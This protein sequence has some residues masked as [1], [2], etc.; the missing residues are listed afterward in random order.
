[1]ESKKCK[2]CHGRGFKGRTG[3][4][5]LMTVDDSIRDCINTGADASTIA[6]TAVKAGMRPLTEDGMRK[7]KQGITT[8]AEVAGISVHAAL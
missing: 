4:F 3:I 1:Q 2:V 5:E 7:V 8:E 6:A